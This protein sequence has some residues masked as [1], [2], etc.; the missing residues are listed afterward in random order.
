LAGPAVNVLIAMVLAAVLAA[1]L[2]IAASSDPGLPARLLVGMLSGGSFLFNLAILNVIL[3]VFN[4]VPAF[5]MDGGRVLRS[6]LAQTLDYVQATQIAASIGQTLAILFGVIGLFGVPGLLA[7]QPMLLFIALFVY[8]GAEQEAHMVRVRSVMRG[9]PTWAAMVT[10]FRTVSPH[11]P[12]SAALSELLAGQ[13]QDFPVLEG[14]QI[15]GMLVR[16]DLL[17]AIAEGRHD[18]PVGEVMRRECRVVDVGEMLDSTFQRMR[19]GECATLPVLREGRLVG[20]VTL[21]NVGE[22][23]MIQSALHKAKARGDVDD[24]YHVESPRLRLSPRLR[25]DQRGDP[26]PPEAPPP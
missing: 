19:E 16:K 22:W 13:Q 11:D 15:A 7:Q 18:Q 8:L 17:A 5:P 3:V 26:T 9:V 25:P 14:G 12:L 10:R 23:M 24:I 1:Q 2:A 20:I 21:E 6:L 4:L